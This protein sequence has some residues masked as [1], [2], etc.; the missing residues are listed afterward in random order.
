MKNFEKEGR[1]SEFDIYAD[2]LRVIK[3]GAKRKTKI[4]Y[5]ANLNF[6]LLKKYLS[7]MGAEEGGLGLLRLTLGNPNP[8]RPEIEITERGLEYLEWYDTLMGYTKK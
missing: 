7:R 1:R 2:I 6:D 4:V 8:K 3:D 5:S